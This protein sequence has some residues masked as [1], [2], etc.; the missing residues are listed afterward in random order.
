MRVLWSLTR[1]SLIGLALVE[2]LGDQFGQAEHFDVHVIVL[3]R[4]FHDDAA[5][6][7]S[8]FGSRVAPGMFTMLSLRPNIPWMSLSPGAMFPAPD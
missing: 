3:Q 4:F 6:K 7:A 2:M 8:R 1:R 5:A